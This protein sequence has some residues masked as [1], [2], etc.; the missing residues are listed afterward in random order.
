MPILNIKSKASLLDLIANKDSGIIKEYMIDS[1]NTKRL[2]MLVSYS[3]KLINKNI[4]PFIEVKFQ[5]K[6]GKRE[7]RI[8]IVG[9]RKNVI[10]LYKISKVQNYDKNA[11]E[12]S[13]LVFE[14]REFNSEIKIKGILLFVEKNTDILLIQKFINSKNLG[15]EAK[16]F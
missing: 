11:I 5:S 3:E 6:Y 10:T 14:I 9:K 8:E 13:K 15:I 12:L 4:E 16:I 7:K 1:T 2:S